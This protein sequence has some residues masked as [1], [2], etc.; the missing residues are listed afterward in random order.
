MLRGTKQSCCRA[1]TSR[2]QHPRLLPQPW[3][4]TSPLPPWPLEQ[5]DAPEQSL[6]RW[7]EGL[8][9]RDDARGEVAGSGDSPA[10]PNATSR[11]PRGCLQ[12]VIWWPEREEGGNVRKENGNN[13]TRCWGVTGR[14]RRRRWESLQRHFLTG[15]S[16]GH[17]CHDLTKKKGKKEDTG[18]W[19]GVLKFLYLCQSPCPERAHA[20]RKLKATALRSALLPIQAKRNLE[21]NSQPVPVAGGLRFPYDPNARTLTP[22]WSWPGG[23]VVHPSPRGPAK[24]RVVSLGRGSH[25]RGRAFSWRWKRVTRNPRNRPSSP[26]RP[27]RTRGWQEVTRVW[28]LPRAQRARKKG[29]PTK[30]HHTSAG[31]RAPTPGRPQQQIF[32]GEGADAAPDPVFFFPVPPGHPGGLNK[33]WGPR[34]PHLQPQGGR[35][36][37]QEGGRTARSHPKSR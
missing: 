27:I 13:Q 26:G 2:R 3:L 6:G 28:V 22:A 30:R 24:P 19:K 31:R 29:I 17:P 4:D 8:S 5:C 10:A 23:V 14:G 15:W 33:V 11:Q 21:V 34:T 12:P 25:R 9:C 16:F 32:P 37:T 36:G 1:G 20:W 18:S 35:D 7:G